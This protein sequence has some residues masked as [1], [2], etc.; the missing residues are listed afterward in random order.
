MSERWAIIIDERGPRHGRYWPDG[1]FE[2]CVTT[3]ELGGMA[4]CPHGSIAVLWRQMLA[5][6]DAAGA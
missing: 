2:R 5:A 3:V 1:Y 4:Y 6:Q